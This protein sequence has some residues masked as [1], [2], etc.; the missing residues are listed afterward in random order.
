MP[1]VFCH[2]D[3]NLQPDHETK[4]LCCAIWFCG[5]VGCMNWQQFLPLV[6]VLVAV[7]LFVWR[8]SG[9]TA[10]CCGCKCGCSH[11]PEAAVKKEDAGR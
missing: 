6:I 9:K 4:N 7:V 8:S 11:A 1:A 5:Y 10:G 2:S 3:S